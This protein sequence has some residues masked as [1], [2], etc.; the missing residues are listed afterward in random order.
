MQTDR[1]ATRATASFVFIVVTNHSREA[2]FLALQI[3]AAAV[4]LK[5][6]KPNSYFESWVLSAGRAVNVAKAD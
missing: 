4:V 3:R 2:N 1:K 6:A 5:Q